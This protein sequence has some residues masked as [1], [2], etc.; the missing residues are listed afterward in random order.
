M[1]YVVAFD[2]GVASVG[3]A[4]I[5]KT[6]NP[7]ARDLIDQEEYKILES[8][9]NLF[10][11][12][13]AAENV[14]RRDLRQARRIKRREHVRLLDFTKMWK[15]F[16]LEVPE[17]PLNKEMV[18]LKVSALSEEVSLDELYAILYNYLKHRGISYLDDVEDS[19]AKKTMHICADCKSMQK[20]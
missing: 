18:Q 5:E 12:A 8:G 13:N 20:N 3:W 16:G 2:I 7:Q 14:T 11:E 9:S 19:E 1:S 10:Q 17:N 15:A 4:V 6:E